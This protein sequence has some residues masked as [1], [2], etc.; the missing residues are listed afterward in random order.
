[1]IIL[2]VSDLPS[3]GYPINLGDCLLLH[4]TAS[5]SITKT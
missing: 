2:L 1:M 4:E 5:I 3:L